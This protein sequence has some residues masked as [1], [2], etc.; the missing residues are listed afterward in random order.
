VAVVGAGVMVAWGKWPALSTFAGSS[1]MAALRLMQLAAQKG[2]VLSDVL[3]VEVYLLIVLFGRSFK[4]GWRSH[5]QQIIIGLSTAAIAQMSI[6]GIWQAI[7]TSA[8]PTSMDEYQRIMGMQEKL[9]NASNAVY[10]AVLVWWIVC[11]WIDEPGSKTA[12]A[13]AA[14]IPATAGEVIAPADEEKQA[15]L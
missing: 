4:A 13:T 8:K 2:D 14:E 3:T 9:Y 11:L 6:R 5:T 15:E 7:A 10:L 12:A 1:V